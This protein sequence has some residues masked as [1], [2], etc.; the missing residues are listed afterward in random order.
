MFT[1]LAVIALIAIYYDYRVERS[2]LRRE[3][4]TDKVVSYYE[5][6]KIHHQ[7][8]LRRNA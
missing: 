6:R 8:K 7:E 1:I 2:E 4:E 3:R 5:I